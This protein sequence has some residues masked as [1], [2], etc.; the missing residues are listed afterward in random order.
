MAVVAFRTNT[1]P[2]PFEFCPVAGML[3]DGKVRAI[4]EGLKSDL[5]DLRK[6]IDKIKPNALYTDEEL[7]EMQE[8]QNN[9]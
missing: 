6:I 3:S 7:L 1:I 2:R 8:E 5:E 4:T 9:Q